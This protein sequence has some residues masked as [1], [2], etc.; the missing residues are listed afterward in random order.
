MEKFIWSFA[1]SIFKDY[2]VDDDQ[3]LNDCFEYDWKCSKI[4]NLLKDPKDLENTK[5]FL[6]EKYKIIRESYK[7]LSAYSTSEIPCIGSNSIIELLSLC[8]IFDNLYGISD[9]GVN[10]NS[11]IVPTV[12]NQVFNPANALVR[13]EFLEII[14]RVAYDR[15]YRTKTFNTVFDSVK[16]LFT[17]FL[18]TK[19]KDYCSD[20]WRTEK[21]FNETIDITLKAH[22][23][24][25][26]SIFKKF[27]GRKA[28]PGQKAF[29]SLEEFREFCTN[30]GLLND[31]FS[32]REIDA[33]FNQAMMTQTDE[34]FK[35]RHT[36]MNYLEFLEAVCRACDLAGVQKYDEEEGAKKENLTLQQKI[37]NAARLFLKLCPMYLQESFVFPNQ[38]SY[39]KMM[40][41]PK[42]RPNRAPTMIQQMK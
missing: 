12:K 31:F 6:R 11:C 30:A 16:T 41:K 13:Y 4:P 24:I 40:Y 25:F 15:Y 2:N 17:D 28:I 7:T 42:G 8:N 9:F 33:C 38:L 27:S 23:P 5:T 39:E 32:T 18:E 35:K 10:W 29:V 34:I 1:N 20:S 26:D 19:L 36:E 22:K 37:E 3:V 21:Y 14:V